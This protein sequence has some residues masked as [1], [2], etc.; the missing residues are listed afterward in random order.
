MLMAAVALICM[1]LNVSAQ[2]ETNVLKQKGEKLAKDADTEP[3]NWHK[4]CDAARFFLSVED[5]TQRQK[6]AQRA[7][8]IA[9]KMQVK[10]DTI[11]PLSLELIAGCYLIKKDYMQMLNAYD[12]VIRAYIDEFGYQNK[13]IPPIIAYIACWKNMMNMIG[14][15]AFGDVESI[16]H[17]REAYILNSQ[18]PEGQRAVGLEESETIYALAQETLLMEHRNRMKDKV[19]QWYNPEDGKLYTIL[20][21]DDW[22]LEQ[23][24]GFLAT[25]FARDRDEKKKE[26][27]KHGLILMDEEGKVREMLHGEFTSSI[28]CNYHNEKFAI[29]EKSSI[30]L[31]TVTPEERQKMIEALNGRRQQIMDDFKKKFDEKE[32]D[33]SLKIAPNAVKLKREPT[34]GRWV[35]PRNK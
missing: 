28:F 8:E 19:W 34:P 12:M 10:K 20:A 26:E 31:K 21:F 13:L 33:S 23:P 25:M 27:M 35:F 7:L 30:R 18:L 1:T 14:M 29:D 24:E 4:Q 5:T 6:F 15:Y 3:Q 22:T 16:R 11:L 32:K 9:Q 17:L 2:Q